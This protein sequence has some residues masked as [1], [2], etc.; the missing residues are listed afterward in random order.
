MFQCDPPFPL[1]LRT[2]QID[3]A[4]RPA[5]NGADGTSRVGVDVTID[6]VR[7]GQAQIRAETLLRSS[8]GGG[9]SQYP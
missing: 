8:Q 3:M 1:G 9:V 2:F 4:A 7:M 5:S 6:T